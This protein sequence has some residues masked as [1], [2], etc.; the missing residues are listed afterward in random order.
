MNEDILENDNY[1]VDLNLN[2]LYEDVEELLYLVGV[3]D[4]IESV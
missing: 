2:D 1:G 3:E 4:I